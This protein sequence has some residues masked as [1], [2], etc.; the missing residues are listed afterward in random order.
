MISSKFA[1][2]VLKWIIIFG[3]LAII[4]LL[5]NHF[6]QYKIFESISAFCLGI[7]IKNLFDF[8][9]DNKE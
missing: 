1:A 6:P 7:C 9:F 8:I 3:T 2:S 5:D 4:I